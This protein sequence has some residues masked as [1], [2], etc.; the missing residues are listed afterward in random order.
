[1]KSV[2]EAARIDGPEG[3]S[4]GGRAEKPDMATRRQSKCLRG[5]AG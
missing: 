2:N 5:S 1:M 4:L 3:G